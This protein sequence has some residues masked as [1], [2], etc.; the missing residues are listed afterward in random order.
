MPTTCHHHLRVSRLFDYAPCFSDAMTSILPVPHLIVVPLSLRE[1]QHFSSRACVLRKR[2]PRRR[3][4]RERVN[5]L[6]HCY[7]LPSINA[8]ATSLASRLFSRACLA[9]ESR[10]ASSRRRG[11]SRIRRL[12]SA[13]DSLSDTSRKALRRASDAPFCSLSLSESALLIRGR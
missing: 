1:L 6:L 8:I 13:F 3:E 2:Q 4:A 5:M 10:R 11:R 12:C 9:V 7:T